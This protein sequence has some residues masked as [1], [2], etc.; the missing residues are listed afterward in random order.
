MEIQHYDRQ[1]DSNY[2]GKRRKKILLRRPT[3]GTLPEA[4]MID[5]IPM[6]KSGAM[7]DHILKKVRKKIKKAASKAGKGI[8]KAA[9]A[10]AKGLKKAVKTVAKVSVGI[11]KAPMLAPIVPLK[12]M[13]KKALNKKGF[14]APSKTQDLAEAFYNNIVKGRA[15]FDTPHLEYDGYQDNLVTVEIVGAIVKFVKDALSKK[16]AKKS[17]EVPGLELSPVEELVAN[18]SEKVVDEIKEKA[19]DV[20]VEIAP[21]PGSN[22]KESKESG[23]EDAPGSPDRKGRKTK[24]K[25]GGKRNNENKNSGGFGGISTP[26]LLGG[27]AAAVGLALVLR[28]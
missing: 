18:E 17:G 15:N 25:K 22:S 12:P 7:P 26:V 27:A 19:N 1:L 6:V 13:M 3:G 2:L 9:K 5:G 4:V 28:K 8:A 20:G 10:T 24:S 21:L 11:A 14:N 23:V 16:K